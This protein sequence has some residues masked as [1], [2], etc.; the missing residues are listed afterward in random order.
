MVKN[1]QDVNE[2]VT[3]LN[4]PQEKIIQLMREL[5]K[6]SASELVEGIKWNSP[7]YSLDG[8]DI[9]TFNFH[10]K[11]F[12][13]L[14]FHTGPKGKDTHTR[15]QLFID[16]MNHLEWVADKRAIL[17]ISSIEELES[18]EKDIEKIIDKWV[19]KAKV[20]FQDE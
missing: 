8:N 3:S 15:K 18:M 13:S 12:I 11:G 4:H 10:Y 5:I 7:S 9:I 6:R 16:E 20:S 14:V 19:Q 17:K 1:K 2:F